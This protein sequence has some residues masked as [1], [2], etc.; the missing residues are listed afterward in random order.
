MDTLTEKAKQ[1]ASSN[2]LEV[3][4]LQAEAE[5][6]ELKEKISTI[7]KQGRLSCEPHHRF[8]YSGVLFPTCHWWEGKRARGS[9][10]SP[11]RE[12]NEWGE[13][14]AGDYSSFGGTR[15]PGLLGTIRCWITRLYP[16][17]FPWDRLG[18]GR[19]RAR[20][21]FGGACC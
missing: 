2:A 19:A 7:R 8:S 18:A 20:P 21:A 11:A 17:T 1:D 12:R 13:H 4:C 14:A 9:G 3:R 16:D 15:S 10:L 6:V 5:V